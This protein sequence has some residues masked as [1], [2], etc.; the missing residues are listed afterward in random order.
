MHEV[1]LMQETLTIA[2]GRAREEGA[3][4][5]HRLTMRVGPLSGAVPEALEFA[6]EVI[7]RGTIAEGGQ[8]VV[9]SVP[10]VCFCPRCAMEYQPGDLFCICPGCHQPSAEVR[11]GRE[12]ELTSLEV[13]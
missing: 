2:L 11:R 8:L 10:I 6:F 5:I 3:S 9:E 1:G 7:A 13:S 12:M 4:R